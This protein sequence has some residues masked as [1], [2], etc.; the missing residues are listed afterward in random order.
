MWRAGALRLA[1]LALREQAPSA[2]PL[3]FC[4][5]AAHRAPLEASWGRCQYSTG[6]DGAPP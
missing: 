2:V 4:A 1:G 5:P 3:A 6:E